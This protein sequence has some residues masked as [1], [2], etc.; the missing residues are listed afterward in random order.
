MESIWLCIDDIP[1]E[2]FH[3]KFSDKEQ[4]IWTKPISEYSLGISL[5]DPVRAELSIF[6]QDEGCLVQGEVFASIEQPCDVC[7]IP[8]KKNIGHIF[9]DFIDFTEISPTDTT[10]VCIGKSGSAEINIAGILWEEFL[11]DTTGKTHC[12]SSCFGLCS[13]CGKKKVSSLCLCEDEQ[14]KKNNPF[15][16]ILLANRK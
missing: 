10:R 13:L 9:D 16:N 14:N 5:I 1:E 12:S 3:A 4:F 6:L 11:F 15:A 8:V 7:L 2:G